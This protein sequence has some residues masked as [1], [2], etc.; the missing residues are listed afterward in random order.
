VGAP[1]VI[2]LYLL[3]SGVILVVDAEG[4]LLLGQDR[5]QVGQERISVEKPMI[6]LLEL[7]VVCSF[8]YQGFTHGDGPR[9]HQ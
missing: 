3:P 1:F 8:V 7:P 4:I 9:Y 6:L 2:E 5:M